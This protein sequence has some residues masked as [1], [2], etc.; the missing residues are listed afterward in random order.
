LVWR[1]VEF[2]PF[3]L[4]WFVAFKTLSHYRASVWYTSEKKAL[5]AKYLS[6]T[7]V[8]VGVW[9]WQRKIVQIENVHIT[10]TQPYTKSDPNPNPSN[11]NHTT[12]QHA[13]AS[14]QL[15]IVTCPTYPDKFIRDNVVAPFVLV[16]F[17][18]SSSHSLSR[19]QL[20]ATNTQIN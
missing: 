6:Q 17:H 16:Y 15:N 11:S 5:L 13:I 18:L 12:K 19:R 1:G 3:P 9:Q 10:S 2:W 4:T 20:L 7:V 14:I 8:F